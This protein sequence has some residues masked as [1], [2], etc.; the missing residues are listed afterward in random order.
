MKIHSLKKMKMMMSKIILL[1]AALLTISTSAYAEEKPRF[2]M[3]GMHMDVGV[4]DGGAIGVSVRPTLNWLRLNLSGTYNS[5]APGIR[6]GI[7]LDPIKFPVAPTLTLEGGHAFRGSIP[8]TDKFGDV[9]YN[10]ANLHAGLEFGNRDSWRIFLHGGYSWIDLQ[11]YNFSDAV[12]NED[13]SLLISDLRVS[14][15]FAPT[16]KLGFVIYF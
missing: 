13:K 3:V 4:P 1:T 16:A 11:T 15:R 5:I 12:G 2:K 6:G 14:A 9:S 8:F 10:Y 7:T